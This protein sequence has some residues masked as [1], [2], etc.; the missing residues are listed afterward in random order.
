LVSV[1]YFIINFVSWSYFLEE[2][3][4]SLYRWVSRLSIQRK[5]LWLVDSSWLLWITHQTCSHSLKFTL[6]LLSLTLLSLLF[7]SLLMVDLF[8]HWFK[9]EQ[10]DCK[11]E[12]NHSKPRTHNHR[13]VVQHALS[14]LKKNMVKGTY[15]FSPTIILRWDHL[16]Y[17][18]LYNPQIWRHIFKLSLLYVLII[19]WLSWHA[20]IDH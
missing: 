17:T 2:Y 13:E 7:H 8:W 1:V 11:Y 3:K 9:R 12:P 20:I 5:Y 4:L 6:T 18:T 19:M 16:K 10:P 14:E 15:F